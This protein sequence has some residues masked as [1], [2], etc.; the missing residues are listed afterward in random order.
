MF[1][2]EYIFIAVKTMQCY[3]TFVVMKTTV[4]DQKRKTLFIYASTLIIC[5]FFITNFTGL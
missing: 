5:S 4:R 1:K 3:F 2:H